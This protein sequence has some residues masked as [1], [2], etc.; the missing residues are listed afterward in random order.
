MTKLRLCACGCGSSL[1]ELRAD[2]IYASEA[3]SKR[4]RRAASPDKARTKEPT[5]AER[6]LIAL[7]ARG[8]TGLHSHEVRKLGISA[9]PSQRAA[10]LEAKGYEI[11]RTKEFKGR[12]PGVRFTLIAE[13]GSTVAR[14]A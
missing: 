4:A 8:N 2:A 11:K 7:R 10:E 13:P 9:H 14:A 3:C 12:R 5:D 6:M 1:A